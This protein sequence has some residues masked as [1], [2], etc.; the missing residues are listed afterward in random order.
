MRLRTDGP[1]TQAISRL[2]APRDLWVIAA[3]A[4]K[5]AT[6]TIRGLPAWA[7]IGHL[8]PGGRQV[9]AKNGAVTQ[10]FPG[11]GVRVIRFVRPSP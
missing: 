5:P 9:T 10:R 7:K 3:K 11:W 2:G 8:Y 1:R 4:G 6:V